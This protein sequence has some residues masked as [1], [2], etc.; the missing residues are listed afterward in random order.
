V[1]SI[2]RQTTVKELAGLVAG[3]L[4]SYQIEAVLSGGS[5]VTLYSENRYQSKDLDFIT[6]AGLREVARALAPL[7]FKRAAGGRHFTHPGTE[8]LVESQDDQRSHLA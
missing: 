4:R 6:S 8:F 5:L 1:T 3:Q 2:T 7:G